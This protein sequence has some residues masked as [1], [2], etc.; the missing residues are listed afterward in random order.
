MF[1]ESVALEIRG[2]KKVKHVNLSNLKFINSS[3]PI[4]V[5]L[6]G[7][8]PLL[9]PDEMEKF[10]NQTGLDKNEVEMIY[11][12]T[13]TSTTT[14]TTETYE[15]STSEETSTQFEVVTTSSS[16]LAGLLLYLIFI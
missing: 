4:K 8:D 14:T 7:I 5:K 9:T 12:T 11:V 16:K 13:T 3:G 2:N 10:L 15:N 1:L 6:D